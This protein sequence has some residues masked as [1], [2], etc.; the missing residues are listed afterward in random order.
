MNFHSTK[1]NGSACREKG[2]EVKPKTSIPVDFMKRFSGGNP[3]VLT[4]MIP[5]GK[6]T[7][8]KTF[9]PIEMEEMSKFI[10]ARN[11]TENIYFSV[12]PVKN[13]VS[14]KTSKA[15]IK[16]LAWLHVDIDPDESKGLE[17]ARKEIKSRLDHSPLK[18]TVIVDSGNGYQAFWKLNNP[19]SING[20]IESLESE[21]R[22]LE[23]FFKADFC[24]NIDRIMRV[25]GTLNH[26]NK[27]KIQLG[28]T[29]VEAKLIHFGD[30]AYSI[31]DFSAF[32]DLP[33]PKSSKNHE[34]Y[35]IEP[36][37]EEATWKK[38]EIL[39]EVDPD[40]Q[41]RWNGDPAGLSD[42]QQV[43]LIWL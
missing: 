29:I 17:A 24:H 2:L 5:D 38:F 20:N 10:E 30:E 39:C 21:N 13:R 27:K 40:V 31:E 32:G 6:T 28:R 11:Q 4:S 16:E 3:T 1:D 15:D 12:N 18:P 35:K 7:T 26:P 25:P 19:I 33:K 42:A 41:R 22:R 36:I 8:T 43:V 37:D 23:N 14:K 34:E 9:A